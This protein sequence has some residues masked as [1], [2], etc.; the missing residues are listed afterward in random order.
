MIM[1]DSL[2]YTLFLT[3]TYHPL[4]SNIYTVCRHVYT[5]HFKYS[6]HS[7]FVSLHYLYLFTV[8]LTLYVVGHCAFMYCMNTCLFTYLYVYNSYLFIFTYLCSALLSLFI[9]VCLFLSSCEWCVS[10]LRTT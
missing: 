8:Y 4:R 6:F 3:C 10:T 1:I 9:A 5:T 2:K 7:V